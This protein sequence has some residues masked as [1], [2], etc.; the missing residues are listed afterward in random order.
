MAGQREVADVGKG[1]TFV[2]LRDWPV[3]P[4]V[5]SWALGGAVSISVGPQVCPGPS[6]GWKGLDVQKGRDVASGSRGAW[7][8]AATRQELGS[9]FEKCGGRPA[10]C[11]FG[12]GIRESPGGVCHGGRLARNDKRP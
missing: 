8:V 2:I 3:T 5:P 12:D 6:R 4:R 9:S 11:A 1:G 7:A 10:S